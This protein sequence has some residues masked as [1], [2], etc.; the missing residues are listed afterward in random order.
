LREPIVLLDRT[1][2]GCGGRAGKVVVRVF[3][4]LRKDTKW[5]RRKLAPQILRIFRLL[6][7]AKFADEPRRNRWQL[8]RINLIAF[9]APKGAWPFTVNRHHQHHQAPA[10]LASPI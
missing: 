5:R 3:D 7:R 6:W 4:R 2:T 10:V 8:Q 9:Q 1:L